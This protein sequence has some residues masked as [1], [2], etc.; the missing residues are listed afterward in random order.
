MLWCETNARSFSNS[1]DMAKS[2][3]LAWILALSA[4]AA[5]AFAGPLGV[6]PFQGANEQLLGILNSG[7]LKFVGILG[8]AA[9]GVLIASGETRFAMLLV[10]VSTVPFVMS[11]MANVI[12]GPEANQ[13]AQ[14]LSSSGSEAPSP[15]M[16]AFGIVIV[17]GIV[18]TVVSHFRSPEPSE[19]RS[20][21]GPTPPP[22]PDVPPLE[23]AEAA[24]QPQP[25]TPSQPAE[26]V[27]PERNTDDEEVVRNRRKIVL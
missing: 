3:K 4:I 17:T 22:L 5:T 2:T 14:A 16:I 21:T 10:G 15:F 23:S 18:F 19:V 25:L 1:Y 24:M 12:L 26:A 11:L 6:S 27:Q 7:A 20:F 13:S 9:A 8:I